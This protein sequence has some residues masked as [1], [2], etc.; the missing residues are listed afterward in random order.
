[1][2]KFVARENIKHYRELPQRQLDEPERRR[3][4]SLLQEEE[5]RLAKLDASA[6]PFNEPEKKPSQS[7]RANGSD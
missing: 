3:I 4:L 6:T 7:S 5:A 2:D 1:M